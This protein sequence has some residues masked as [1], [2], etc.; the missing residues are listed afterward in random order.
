MNSCVRLLLVDDEPQLLMDLYQSL[1]ALRPAWMVDYAESGPKAL[2]RMA[3]RSY[4]V[5]VSDLLMPRMTGL[6]L[7]TKIRERRPATVRVVLSGYAE[8]KTGL[9]LMGPAH[10]YLAKPCPPE[11]LVARSRGCWRGRWDPSG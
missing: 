10:H 5:V 1:R 8:W 4:D 2:Q 6:E 11:R 3:R 7:F 9:Q